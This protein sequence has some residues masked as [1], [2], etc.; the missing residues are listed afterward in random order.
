[1]SELSAHQTEFPAEFANFVTYV[2]SNEIQQAV[3]K[4]MRK[5]ASFGV[6]PR[7]LFG[8]RYFFHEEIARFTDNPHAFQLDIRSASSIRAASFIAG[9]NRARFGMTEGESRHFGQ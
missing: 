7:Q 5:L 6:A 9:T 3:D 2:G 1:M 4:A 8:T